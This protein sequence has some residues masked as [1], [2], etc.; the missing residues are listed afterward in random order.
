VLTEGLRWAGARRRMAGDKGQAAETIGAH[1]E[2]RRRVLRGAGL[3][4]SPRGVPAELPGDEAELLR[5][6]AGSRVRGSG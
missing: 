6:S 3:L 4:G 1:G 5:S 2:G